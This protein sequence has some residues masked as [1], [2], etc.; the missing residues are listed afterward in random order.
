MKTI[1][2]AIELKLEDADCERLRGVLRCEEKDLDKSLAPYVAAASHEYIDMFVGS[3]AITNAT[4]VK[5]RRLV[6]MILHGSGNVPDAATIARLFKL[7]PSQASGLIRNVYAKHDVK[8]AGTVN[9]QLHGIVKAA[10]PEEKGGKLFVVIPDA[11][12]VKL[13]NA[14]LAEAAEV[15]TSVALVKDTANRYAMDQSTQTYLLRQRAIS[16]R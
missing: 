8:L 3:G 16:S 13:L 2:V 9:A 7:T 15:Q 14:R 6:S 1:T 11:G 10:K 5:E 4:E 12:L